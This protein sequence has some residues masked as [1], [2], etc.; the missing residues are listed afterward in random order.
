[1]SFVPFFG[2]SLVVAVTFAL[3]RGGGPERG[4][5]TLFALGSIGSLAGGWRGM[6]GGFAV[7]PAYLM[8][9]DSALLAAMMV[10]TV[11]ANRLWLI[12]ATACQ[13]LAVIGHVTKML[14]PSIIP[15][16][17]AFLATIWS[18]PMVLLLL[19]GTMACVRRRR[20][21]RDI[22]DWKGSSG[23]RGLPI[24]ARLRWPFAPSSRR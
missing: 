4:A 24:P 18:W 22:P 10:L 1:M 21:G 7:V 2:V 17:Y 19:G 14:A 20:E 16:S 15:T 8:L 6:P 13:L 12:P 23:Q 9:V 3:L 11:Q 5:A